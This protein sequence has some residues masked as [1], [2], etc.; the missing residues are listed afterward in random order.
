MTDNIFR[1]SDGLPVGAGDMSKSVYDQDNDGMVDAAPWNGIVG[2]PYVENITKTV[3]TGKDYATIQEAIDFFNGKTL[4]GTNQI[5]LDP[6]NYSENLIFTG[7]FPS[8]SE[9]LQ[10]VGDSR[11]I[12]SVRY[13]ASGTINIPIFPTVANGGSGNCNI[14]KSGNTLTVTGDVSNPNFSAGGIVAGDK[15]IIGDNSGNQT[16]GTVDSV[17]G[18]TITLTATAPTIGAMGSFIVILPNRRIISPEQALNLNTISVNMTALTVIGVTVHTPG[19]NGNRSI[20]ANSAI[21]SLQRVVTLGGSTGVLG[22]NLSSFRTDSYVHCYYDTTLSSTVGI[23]SWQSQASTRNSTIFQKPN[24]QSIGFSAERGNSSFDC[25]NSLA[26]GCKYAFRAWWGSSYMDAINCYAINSEI[27]YNADLNG[28]VIAT[29]T[30]ARSNATILYDPP[31]SGVHGNGGSIVYTGSQQP[32][33]APVVLQS[34]LTSTAW[35]GDARSTTAKTLIDLSAVFG[36]PANVKAVL[37]YV[38]VRDSSSSN[39]D[40]WLL[41]SPNN[42]AGSGIEFSTERVTNDVWIA[43]QATIPCNNDG[44]IYFQCAA[45]GAST[46]DV[47]LEIWGYYL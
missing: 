34:P 1:W 19:A 13:C 3:G 2:R 17:S 20:V 10:L 47:V 29:S 30:S 11:L 39:G 22:I 46:L 18:N 35:D 8:N 9:A 23:G 31:F 33:S 14:S 40:R 41:L 6:G 38:R 43:K 37:A 15:L 27:G 7:Y 28:C 42:T 24:T 4:I 44:D 16:E 21:L 5:V 32:I 12:P 25:R 26:V 36:V 45:S